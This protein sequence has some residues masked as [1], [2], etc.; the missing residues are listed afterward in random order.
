M[1]GRKQYLFKCFKPLNDY[2]S[3]VNL[4]ILNKSVYYWNRHFM[5]SCMVFVPTPYIE[6]SMRDDHIIRYV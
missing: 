3:V 6:V 1:S 4:C 5:L 2:F